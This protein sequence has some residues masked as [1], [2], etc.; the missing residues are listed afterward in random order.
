M[1]FTMTMET[2]TTEQARG[3]TSKELLQNWEDGEFIGAGCWG[4]YMDI[5]HTRQI[6]NDSAAYRERER[7]FVSVDLVDFTWYKAFPPLQ[8]M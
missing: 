8:V 3:K 6:S 5:Q 4:F 1:F 2:K 7:M